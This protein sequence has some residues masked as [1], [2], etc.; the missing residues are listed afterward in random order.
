MTSSQRDDAPVVPKHRLRQCLL[1]LYLILH[2]G[3]SLA[4]VVVWQEDFV[5]GLTGMGANGAWTL[6]G[7]NQLWEHSFVGTDGEWSTGIPPFASTTNANGF[8]LFD[9]DAFNWP[10]SPNYVTPIGSLT[11]PAVDLSLVP[12]VGLRYQSF[13]RY[14]CDAGSSVLT[15]SVSGDGGLSW[16][17]Y[18]GV[19]GVAVNQGSPN[20][21]V[22]ELDITAIAGSQSDV[23]VR[24]TFGDGV[25]SHYYWTVDDVEFL[26]L[27]YSDLEVSKEVSNDTPSN[28]E[29]I[30]YTVSVTNNG[31]ED[32]TGVSLTDVLP[33]G[34][35]R[36]PTP[37]NASQGSFDD[38]SGLW[39]IGALSNSAVAT[40]ILEV[41]VDSDASSLAQPIINST[42]GLTLDQRDDNS[43]NDIGSVGLTALE[44]IPPTVTLLQSVASTRSEVGT[45]PDQLEQDEVTPVSITQ[46]YVHFSEPMS[47]DVGDS[48]PGDVTNPASYLLIASGIDESFQTVDCAGG[49]VGPDDTGVIVDGVTYDGTARLRINGGVALPRGR[50]RFMA[51]GSSSLTDIVGNDLDGNGDGNGGDDFL[52]DFEITADQLLQNPNFDDDLGSWDLTGPPGGQLHHG[53]V[54]SATAPTSGSAE[55]INLTGPGQTWTLSQCVEVIPN[56]RYHAGLVAR[57]DSPMGGVEP[58][59]AMTVDF[60]DGPQCTSALIGSVS[61]APLLGDTALGWVPR[62]A[63][64]S[65]GAAASA[66]VTLVVNAGSSSSFTANLDDVFFRDTFLLFVDGFESL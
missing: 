27:Q 7:V 35:T 44:G 62:S 15:V 53:T 16:T 11:S 24:F 5:N 19:N 36:T 48:A 52:S 65:S 49:I 21:F 50:Y 3:V 37:P 17:D 61:T 12:V 58:E 42:S 31:P 40:L 56:W 22:H 30:T 41:T 45:D 46:I 13:F 14:C 20:P 66:L 25:N 55:V 28:D 59:V 1:A 54:D 63:L 51:C 33:T 9:A 32:A 23:R 57:I 64:M 8:M 2:G 10:L 18:D 34:V 43:G 38:L 6:S 39:T 4:Q 60:F 26:F 47:D 29:V